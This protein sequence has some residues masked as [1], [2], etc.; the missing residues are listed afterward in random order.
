MENVLNRVKSEDLSLDN[1]NSK[2]S[3]FNKEN[4]MLIKGDAVEQSN[5][6][7][8]KNIGAKIKLLIYGFRCGRTNILNIN[9]AMG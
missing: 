9:Y 7:Y 5:T 6:Y 1:V 4:Y 2:L 8:T 3:V